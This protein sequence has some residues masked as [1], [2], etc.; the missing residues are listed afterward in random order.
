MSCCICES[1]E[2]FIKICLGP[3]CSSARGLGLP[4]CTM[5]SS[6]VSQDVL[7]EGAVSNAGEDLPADTPPAWRGWRVGPDGS[8]SWLHSLVPRSP[9]CTSQISPMD[10]RSSATVEANSVPGMTGVSTK[11]RDKGNLEHCGPGGRFI[12]TSSRPHLVS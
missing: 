3:V 12:R 5:V 4:L 7:Y 1:R 2:V 8:T 10:L 11:S 9:T 6:S